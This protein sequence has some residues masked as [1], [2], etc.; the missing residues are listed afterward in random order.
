VI[1]LLGIAVT[2]CDSAC[3][4]SCRKGILAVRSCWL[5]RCGIFLSA[6]SNLVQEPWPSV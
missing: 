4:A 2:F 1:H 3:F 5:R 6:L